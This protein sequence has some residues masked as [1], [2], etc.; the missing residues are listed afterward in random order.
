ML[1]TC[2]N[3]GTYSGF[4]T[5]LPY[6]TFHKQTTKHYSYGGGVS[7]VTVTLTGNS[8][9]SCHHAGITWHPNPHRHDGQK[10]AHKLSRQLHRA[11]DY[12]PTLRRLRSDVGPILSDCP[13]FPP[14]T[15]L[16]ASVAGI[17][18][19]VLTL[20]NVGANV[21][22]AGVGLGAVAVA[23]AAFLA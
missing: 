21:A 11:S 22:M 17:G 8:P 12:G 18:A 9:A 23:A 3:Y 6:S 2:R 5:K 1:A 16:A 14:L 15:A 7:Y 20:G 13:D 4:L 10:Q 19:G